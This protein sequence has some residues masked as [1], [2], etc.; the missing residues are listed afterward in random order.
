MCGGKKSQAPAAVCASEQPHIDGGIICT[1]KLVVSC[2][3]LNALILN[4]QI[5]SPILM[6]CLTY[7]LSLSTAGCERWLLNFIVWRSDIFFYF[8]VLPSVLFQFPN[9][10]PQPL[11]RC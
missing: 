8:F 7:D 2:T 1:F 4:K 6:S 9:Y 10:S 11:Q 3:S 5:T